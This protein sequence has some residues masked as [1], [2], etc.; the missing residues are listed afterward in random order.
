MSASALVD[1][2]DFTDFR[3]GMRQMP[4]LRPHSQR[5]IQIDSPSL[6]ASR[7]PVMYLVEL[8]IDVLV[9]RSVW[10]FT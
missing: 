4:V 3:H 8:S 2:L 10:G 6:W 5:S 1:H 7:L 9:L